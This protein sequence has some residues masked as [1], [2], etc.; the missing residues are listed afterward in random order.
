MTFDALL[1][2]DAGEGLTL[3]V[4]APDPHPDLVDRLDLQSATVEQ[5]TLPTEGTTGFLVV[6]RGDRFVTALDLE[7]VTS[8]FDPPRYDPWDD[9]LLTADYTVVLE[10]FDDERWRTLEPPQLLAVT[11]AIE[12]RA[13]RVGAGVLRAGF[14]RLSALYV[15]TPIY[16]RIAADTDLE[17]HVYGR[18][19][20]EPPSIPQTTIHAV[21]ES[22][23]DD[24]SERADDG[25][26]P[27]IGRYWFLTYDGGGNEHQSCAILAKER[28]SNVYAGF[29]TFDTAVAETIAGY[30]DRTYD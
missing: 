8:F 6:R 21:G 7:G 12:N 23:T 26:K 19:D 20:W 29:W 2:D 16:E 15:Q 27:D 13:V 5:R 3:I 25:E 4:Y 18:P 10:T 11:R 30:V 24:G 17:I 9:D 28:R 1:E 14:Q 22:A